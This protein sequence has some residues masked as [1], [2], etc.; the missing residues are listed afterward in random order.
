[1]SGLFL[2]SGEKTVSKR[3]KTQF[4]N[5]ISTHVRESGFRKPGKFWLWNPE[6]WVLD[7]G[8]QLKESGIPLTIGIQNPVLLTNTEIQ[9]LESGIHSVDSRI[10][11]CPEFHYMERNIV[12]SVKAY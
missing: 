2:D 12:F 6:S 4:T 3:V 11:D 7:S 5:N 8:I 1:M 10:Q 9:Y